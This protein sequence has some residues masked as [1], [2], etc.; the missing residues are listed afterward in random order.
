MKE[1]AATKP[2]TALYSEHLAAG[3]KMVDFAGLAMPISYEGIVSEHR[4]VRATAGIFDVSH[5]GQFII[6][7]GGA[8]AFLDRLT[9]NRVA[10]LG[11]GRVQYSAMCYEDGGFIDDLL[12]Y[13]LSDGYM[14]VVNAS[15]RVKDLEWIR[16]HAPRDVAVEDRTDERAIVAIQG[17][18]SE[19]I[20][21]KLCDPSPSFLAY[22]GAAAVKVLG[23]PTLVSRTGYTGEDGFEIY[24][25]GDEAPAIWASLLEAGKGDGI[26]PIGLGARDTLRLE[27]GYCLYGNDI[28]Q[29]RSPVEAGLMWITKLD[30]GEFI[31][32]EA[33]QRISESGPGE[34]LLGFELTGRGIPRHG[35]RIL[36]KGRE[37][38]VVTSG[39]FS[40]SLEKGIGMGYFASDAPTDVE[41]EIRDR[42]AAARMT[43][44]PF[45]RGGSV[46]RRK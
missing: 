36:A 2:G 44:V 23:R 43:P 12:V 3:A 24:C 34:R 33:I 45:Y 16:S 17:P 39:T 5:M 27:M 30:K 4:R 15:N 37:V 13:R 25:A 40:P 41:I 11:V 1:S 22:Y 14:L 38:G 21:S 9:T 10:T 42:T 35:H 26:A 32:R 31:G 8:I 46:H 28:D 19:H 29:N 20:L 18:R 7:G 6:S